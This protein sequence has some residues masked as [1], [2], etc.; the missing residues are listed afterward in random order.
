MKIYI[1]IK[2]NMNILGEDKIYNMKIVLKSLMQSI[3]ITYL[4]R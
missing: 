1:G 3:V 2:I 4:P